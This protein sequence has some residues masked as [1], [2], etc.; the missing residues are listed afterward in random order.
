[1]TLTPMV[2]TSATASNIGCLSHKIF[3][4]IQEANQ[5]H[6]EFL[7]I[8][9]TPQGNKEDY[10]SPDLMALTEQDTDGRNIMAKITYTKNNH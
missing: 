5:P 10:D 6:T 7:T 1:M 2:I 3:N 9:G 8:V 4:I